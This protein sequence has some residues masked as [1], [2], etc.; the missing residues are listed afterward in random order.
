L[1]KSEIEIITIYKKRTMAL[2]YGSDKKHA[3][4]ALFDAQKLAFAP[5]MFQAAKSLRDL[6][7]LEALKDN[8]DIDTIA[9]V[10][11]DS[12]CWSIQLLVQRR[13]K[14]ST[15]DD[16]AYDNSILIQFVFKGLGSISGSSARDT[17]EQSIYS[18]NDSLQ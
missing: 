1:G 18:Y 11:Y 3:V 15:T 17:L 14:N 6:G 2:N 13:L 12:C 10:A 4:D 8:K 16:N 5:I 9:G 7:I